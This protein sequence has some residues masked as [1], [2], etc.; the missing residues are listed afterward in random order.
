MIKKHKYHNN[1]ESLVAEF[2]RTLDNSVRSLSEGRKKMYKF[3]IDVLEKFDSSQGENTASKKKMLRKLEG[4]IREQF[5]IQ[6]DEKI[7]SEFDVIGEKQKKS[8]PSQNYV[9]DFSYLSYATHFVKSSI[10]KIQEI[11]EKNK[12]SNIIND[13][14]YHPMTR[15]VLRNLGF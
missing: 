13:I 5:G 7:L 11:A 12:P 6:T 1:I 3:K 10:K 4:E 8:I 9:E 15:S 14:K 2:Q